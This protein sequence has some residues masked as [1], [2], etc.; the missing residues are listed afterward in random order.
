MKSSKVSIDAELIPVMAE[1]IATPGDYL[2]VAFGV[3]VGVQEYVAD[4]PE[5]EIPLV[6]S[7]KATRNKR[8]DWSDMVSYDRLLVVLDK[9]VNPTMRRLADQLNYPTNDTNARNRFGSW[10]RWLEYLG[11]LAKAPESLMRRNPM[12]LPTAKLRAETKS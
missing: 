2:I 12:W 11:Y 6:T 9:V 10:L 3:C 1:I 5:K 7:H 8:S 4:A